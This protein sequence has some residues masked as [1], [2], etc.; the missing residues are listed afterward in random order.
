MP[1]PAK[2]HEYYNGVCDDGSRPP[3]ISQELIHDFGP[4]DRPPFAEPPPKKNTPAHIAASKKTLAGKQEHHRRMNKVALFHERMVDLGL[5]AMDVVQEELKSGIAVPAMDVSEPSR[6][7]QR[8]EAAGY[9]HRRDAD[10]TPPVTSHAGRMPMPRAPRSRLAV[11]LAVI[12]MAQRSGRELARISPELLKLDTELPQEEADAAL[13]SEIYL[14]R[15]ISI[16][17]DTMTAMDTAYGELGFGNWMPFRFFDQWI[18][19]CGLF[20]RILAANGLMHSDN[21]EC[22]RRIIDET[23]PITPLSKDCYRE[24]KSHKAIRPPKSMG[25]MYRAR[26]W[27]DFNEIL[28]RVD[29][30]RNGR[31]PPL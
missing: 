15:A 26:E 3:I 6:L 31:G 12:A 24:A 13:K 4:H 18:I 1:V 5:V 8:P 22:Y 21:P 27:K 28:Q 23:P 9:D 7:C 17:T 25:Y 10:A 14:D 30:V 20:Q 11:A 16:V 19:F 2:V 29:D